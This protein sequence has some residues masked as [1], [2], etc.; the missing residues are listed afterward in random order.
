MPI[1]CPATFRRNWRPGSRRAESG[2]RVIAT[3]GETLLPLATR[4]LF[5]TDLAF[6]LSAIEITLPPL[7]QRL[8]DLPLSCNSSWRRKTRTA[9]SSF[10]A[11]RR[12]PWIG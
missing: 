5:R 3:A 4:G 12:R 11:G 10:A 6:A 1:K 7:A 2:A 8:E 9:A